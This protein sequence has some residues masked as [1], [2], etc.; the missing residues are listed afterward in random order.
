MKKV[1]FIGLGDMWDE[2][3]EED[4]NDAPSFEIM[5]S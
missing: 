2:D 3:E 5:I 1:G 4:F